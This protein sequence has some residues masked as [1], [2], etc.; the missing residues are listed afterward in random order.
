DMTPREAEVA[1]ARLREEI[2]T[3]WQT[4]EHSAQRMTVANERDNLL[5]FLGNVIYRVLPVFIERYQAQ[6]GSLPPDTVPLRFGSWV[7]GDMDGNPNVNARTVLDTLTAH[8]ALIVRR[9]R[10]ELKDLY[11]L[12][13]Q[14]RSRVAVDATIDARIRAYA[15]EHAAQYESISHRH[16]G[17][18]YRVL[19]RLMSAR[20]AATAA[21]RAGGYRTAR[22]FCADLDA[23][24]DSLR[25]HNGEHAGVFQVERLAWR[26]RVF[27]FHL[28]AL[29]VR[30]ESGVFRRSIGA[31]L[32]D[33]D[34]LELDALVR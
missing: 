9:Y 20:L 15:A 23:I 30:Q 5:F 10:D 16:R 31:L 19:L 17:M 1:M 33:A 28:A 11:R 14:S 26:A 34:W 22:E 29:D 25:R 8:R 3:A 4:E 2:T 13:S 7:G 6:F 12:L 18:P 24:R 32:G 21:D 27:G